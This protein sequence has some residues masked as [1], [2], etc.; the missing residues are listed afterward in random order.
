MSAHLIRTEPDGTAVY[1]GLT[2]FE[3]ACVI[4]RLLMSGK[5]RL[6]SIVLERKDAV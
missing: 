3:Q 5:F 4:F 6:K 1:G 2:R